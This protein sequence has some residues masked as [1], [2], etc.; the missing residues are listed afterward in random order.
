MLSKLAKGTNGQVLKL[1]SGLPAWGTDNNNWNANTKGVAGYVTAPGEVANKVWKTDASG[2][3]AWRDDANTVYSLP[4]AANGTRG[5]VQIGYTANG[6]NYPV[7]LLSEKMFVNVPWTDNNTIPNNGTLTMSTSGTG[8][9]GIA[10]FT[11][12][13]SGPSLFK[14]TSNATSA[15]TAS[16]IVARDAGNF[17]AGTITQL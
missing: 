12:D 14:V 2:N 5:G 15:N 10:T 7:Q 13:Q 6:K 9:S 4:L 16:T 8:L 17:S 1:V 11:A 3:P